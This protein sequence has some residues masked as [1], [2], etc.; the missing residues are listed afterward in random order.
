MLPKPIASY[1]APS[2]GSG[3]HVPTNL[4]LMYLAKNN[5]L[6]DVALVKAAETP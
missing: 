3:A 4:S 6:G 2:F 5:I 1:L